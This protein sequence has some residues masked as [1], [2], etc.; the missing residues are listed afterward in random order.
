MGL[1]L[2]G[3]LVQVLVYAPFLSEFYRQKKMY[4]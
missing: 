1:K 3:E 4:C 2:R